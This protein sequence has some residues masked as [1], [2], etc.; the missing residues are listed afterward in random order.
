MITWT[1][2]SEDGYEFASLPDGVVADDGKLKIATAQPN[3]KGVYRC[4][5]SNVEGHHSADI[6][7]QLQCKI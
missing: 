2:R 6:T 1:F 4:E 7:V 3:H 5:A